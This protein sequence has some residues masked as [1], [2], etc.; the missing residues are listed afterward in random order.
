VTTPPASHPFLRYQ[1][2]AILW[3]LVIFVVSSI[4]QHSIPAFA[5][6]SQDKLLHLLV[7]FILTG[8]VYIALLHQTRFPALSRRPLAWAVIV[9]A[10]Y[11]ITD[12]FHQSF[13]GRSADL[14]DVLADVAGAALMALVVVLV[15]RLRRTRAS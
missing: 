2:P 12:E 11:G 13:T 9:A 3:A 7:Y 4:P 10:V 8:L 5:I 15:R 1:L 6:F 14:L